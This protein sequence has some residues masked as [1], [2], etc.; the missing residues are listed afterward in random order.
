MKGLV[1]FL[2]WGGIVLVSAAALFVT[3]VFI[4]SNRTFDAP[5]PNIT[6]SSDSAVIARGK[7]L[8]TGPAHCTGCHFA[9]DDLAKAVNGEPV[10]LKGGFEFALPLG[11]IRTPNITSDEET[12]IK[13]LSDKEIAR[14]LRYGVFPDGRAVFDFMP[15]HNL[16][17][18]DLKAVISYLRTLP[19]VK[20]AV[21]NREMNF[22]GKAVMA[23]LI[24]PVGP[25]GEP[26]AEVKEDSTSAYGKYL[27]HSVANCVGCHTDRDLMTGAFIGE[28]FA[29]GFQMQSDVNPKLT[30]ITPNI[31][32]DP[33]T[34][35]I[36]QW[37]EDVFIHRFRQGI[38]IAGTPMPWNSFKNMTDLE[39]KAIYRYLQNVAPV[40]KRIASV[41]VATDSL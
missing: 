36:F 31:T 9:K 34:G 28:P 2:K 8:V 22:A 1:R 18:E 14:V 24:K 41:V 12:G 5:Y 27:A 37:T 17:D 26:P 15:F 32:H 25:D 30:F 10:E 33:E 21:V 13:K 20:H 23:F 29:G 6:A 11:I 4:M 35:K 16:S 40:H 39:L 38:Q 7:H 19:P 3:A